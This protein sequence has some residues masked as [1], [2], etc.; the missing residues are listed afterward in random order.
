MKKF[1]LV[2]LTCFFLS[3]HSGAILYTN[4]S[5]LENFFSPAVVSF[6]FLLGAVG[7]I[8]LFFYIPKLIR[9]FGNK[10]ITT[11]FLIVS[12]LSTFLMAVSSSPAVVA[13]SFVLYSSLLTIVFYCLDIFLEEISDDTMTGEIRGAWL[14]IVHLGL[15]VGLITLSALSGV[16][17]VLKPVYIAAS[18][19]FVPA[20]FFVLFFQ[21]DPEASGPK[22]HSMLPF[23]AW[24]KMKSVRRA[25]LARFSLEFFYTFMTIYTPLYLHTVLGFEWSVI[26]V[27]FAVALVPFLFLQWPAGKLADLFIGEKE[28]LIVGFLFIGFSL[29][30]MPFLSAGVV[31]WATVLFCSRI[32]ASLVETM[33]DSY[34]FK[35]VNAEDVGLLSIFRLTR[36]ASVILGSAAGAIALNFLSFD[37]LFYILAVVAFFG[38]K[39]ALLIRDTK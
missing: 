32:G 9:K 18:L 14:T 36:P 6:L 39:E 19:L 20:I 13:I 5:L 2:F 1:I 27:I 16:G 34:F 10:S 38:L 17:D 24:W 12:A 15:I 21:P 7:N 33:T 22:H 35:H 23:K 3:L 8:I 31:V 26:G 28:I 30:F 29:L 25:T 4:S 11:L 37:K